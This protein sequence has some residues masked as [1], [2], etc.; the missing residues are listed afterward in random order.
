MV[1]IDRELRDILGPRPPEAEELSKAQKNRTLR[2]PGQYETKRAV[3]G[4]LVD[5]LT[6]DLPGDYFE[7][8][9]R[10]VRSLE[11]PDIERAA[12]A[13]V[14]PDRMI[15][16]VV[17]DLAEIEEGV[18]DLGFGAVRRLSAAGKLLD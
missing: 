11:L 12:K 17:G 10:K 7:T 5:I 6:Y 15:W 13:T 3:L 9:A 4:A 8:Y 1:E 14:H 18:R 2:L 16:V